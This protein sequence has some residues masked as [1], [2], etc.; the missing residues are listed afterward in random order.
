[1]DEFQ[2]LPPLRPWADRGDKPTDE[3]QARPRRRVWEDRAII[4]GPA[5]FLGPGEELLWAGQPRKGLVLRAADIFLIPFSMMWGGFAVFWEVT[6]LESGAPWFFA[7][8]G[9]LFVLIGL[10]FMAGRF[11]VDAWQRAQTSY[12]VTS[13]RVVIVSGL[14]ARR[15][16]SLSIDTLSEVS[17][18]ER[19]TDPGRSRLAPWP[20]GITCPGGRGSGTRL[21]RPSSWRMKL[22][23]CT[24]SS[25][26]RSGR[27]GNGPRMPTTSLVH[28]WQRRDSQAS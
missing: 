5:S 11:W 20:R 15:V 19:G 17:L 27:P 2:A 16:K 4:N 24:R 14:F 7:I 26:R 10:Y 23:Q 9:L 21:V 1:M 13:E 3:V 8:W 25:A 6:V 18:T 22:G 28:R 12:A